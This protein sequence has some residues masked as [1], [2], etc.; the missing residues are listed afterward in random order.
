[1]NFYISAIPEA[2]IASFAFLTFGDALMVIYG[3]ASIVALL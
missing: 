3:L 1:M 2:L